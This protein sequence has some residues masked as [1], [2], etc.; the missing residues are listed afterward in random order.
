MIEGTLPIRRRGDG[1]LEQCHAVPG[2]VWLCAAAR[3]GGS[4]CDGAA[5]APGP[6]RQA[7][8]PHLLLPPSS[9]GG[10]LRLRWDSPLRSIR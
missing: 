10:L 2:T 7:G 3:P 8:P 4:V 5:G 1:K 9:G 6:G